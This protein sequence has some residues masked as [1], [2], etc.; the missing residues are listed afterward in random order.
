MEASR[1]LALLS[2]VSDG[3][4]TPEAAL[5]RLQHLPFVDLGVA[6][7]DHHRALRQGMPEVVFGESKTAEQ[8]VLIVRE[9]LR[10]DGRI[11][12]IRRDALLCEFECFGFVV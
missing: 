6:R 1:I 8:I 9:L 7:V 10:V 3:S 11:F 2:D 12:G 4:L 5:Q